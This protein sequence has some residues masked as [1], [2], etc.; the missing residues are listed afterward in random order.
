MN[1]HERGFLTF[2]AE[3]TRQRMQALLELGDKRRRDVR[4]LLHHAVRFDSRL[5]Q[6]LTGGD[7]FA[8]PVEALLRKAGATSECY[9]LAAN[10]QLDGRV[11]RLR[12][13]LDAI[14]GGGDGAFVSCIPGRLAFYEYAGT[15]SSYILNIRPSV[16]NALA[17]R[18]SVSD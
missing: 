6:H 5:S 10:T 8:G 7:A 1:E 13:A 4:A 18:Q 15:K 3:P 17:S 16:R 9:V 2:L 12:E 14:I 11:M